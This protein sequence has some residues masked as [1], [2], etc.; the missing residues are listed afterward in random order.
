MTRSLAAIATLNAD[1]NVT[2]VIIQR[3]VPP[4]IAIKELQA[5][6]HPLKDVSIIPPRSA[7]SSTWCSGPAPRSPRSRF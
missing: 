1:H 6:V 4:S 3:P 2:G 5:A 7:T